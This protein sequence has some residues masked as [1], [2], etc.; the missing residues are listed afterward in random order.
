MENPSPV[1]GVS[2]NQTFSPG[3][4]FRRALHLLRLAVVF[5]VLSTVAVVLLYR[6]VPPPLTPLMVLRLWDQY[7]A[8]DPLTLK[9]DWEPLERISPWMAAAVVTS[10][11]QRFYEHSGFDFAAIEK[12]R[13]HNERVDRV[14]ERGG[15][16]GRMRGASTI[17]QQTAKNVFLWPARS[18]TRKGLEVWFTF[19][20]ETLWSKERILE[21]YLNVAETGDGL[22]GAPIA[23]R[24]YFGRDAAR[25]TRSQAA[26]IA[27][28]LPRPRA[29]SPSHPPRHVFRRQAWILRQI[30]GYY[31]PV[32]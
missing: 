16:G 18:W 30:S 28:T 7:R 15:R 31:R 14:R 12:A 10:E 32:E 5:F 13:R 26:L 9:K 4:L 6:F 8:G 24:H 19:L 17:S 27:A 29:W 3:R 11:D 25:L 21:V 23:A 1:A 20:I 22:Y 2:R